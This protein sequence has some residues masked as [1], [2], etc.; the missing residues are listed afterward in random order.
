MPEPLHQFAAQILRAAGATEYEATVVVDHLI[1]S[2]L[3]GYDSHG[4]MRVLQYVDE[5]TAGMIE[6]GSRWRVEREWASGA[7]LDARGLFGQVAADAAMRLAL[8]KARTTAVAVVTVRRA[9]HSGRLGTYVELAAANNMLGWVFA[10]GGGGGQ[11]VA[12]FGGCQRRLSTN[13]LA[14]G[15]PCGK[16]FPLV[17]DISTS[18]APEGKVRHYLQSGQKLPHAWLVGADG[19]ATD[20]PAQLYADIGAALL[21]FGG[22]VGHKGFGLALMVDVLAGALADAGCPRD[23]GSSRVVEP[24]DGC[25]LC[26]MVVDIQRFIGLSDFVDHVARMLDFVTSSKPAAGFAEVLIPGEFE[27]RQRLQRQ[28][29]GIDVP[30]GVWHDLCQLAETLGVASG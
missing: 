4:V 17:V 12:P 14:F 3:S 9:S 23:L 8:D 19:R 16:P 15:A 13:P 28:V 2:N 27:Y 26:F 29:A 6:P 24:P 5:L 25:G 11:W 7:V 1:L 18:V 10:N 20:D 21:P 22:D 30:D